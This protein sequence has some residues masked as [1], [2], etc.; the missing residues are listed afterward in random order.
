MEKIVHKGDDYIEKEHKRSAN[1]CNNL[2]SSLTYAA[3]V[4]VLLLVA[5]ASGPFWRRKH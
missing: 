3:S 1:P 5:T 2:P 4:I